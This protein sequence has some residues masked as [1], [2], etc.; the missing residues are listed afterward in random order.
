MRIRLC[1]S[2]LLGLLVALS[3]RA[4]QRFDTKTAS[5]GITYHDETSAYRD[6]AVVVMPGASVVLN[7]VDG[8]PG[9]YAASTADGILVGQ[10]T[11]RW[12]W[13]APD[14][15]GTYLITID[16]PGKKDSIALHAFVMVPRTEVKDGVLNGYRIGEYPAPPRTAH[17]PYLPPPGFVE[18][19]KENLKTKLSP[20]FTLEQFLCKEDTTRDFPKYVLFKERLPLKLEAIL[21]RVNAMGFDVDTLHVMSAF[22]TPYYNRAIG[23]VEFSAHQWGSAADVYVDPKRAGR[24]AD[25][26]RDGRIDVQDSKTLYDQ[27]ERMLA[28]KELAPLQGGMGFYPATSTHPPFVHVDVRGTKARWHG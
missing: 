14:R 1:G 5:F 19:T 21:E 18:V 20:H 8:P 23:D 28:V 4:E 10:S 27:V 2:L 26:N 24:M 13:T 6:A 3:G 15:P 12:T 11:H 7:T 22:R 9:D 16:G 25:L 17:S